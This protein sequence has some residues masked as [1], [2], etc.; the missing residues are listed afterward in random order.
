M[1]RSL[2]YWTAQPS[3]QRT[4]AE[5]IEDR[6]DVNQHIWFYASFLNWCGAHSQKL[7]DPRAKYPSEEHKVKTATVREVLRQEPLDVRE[8][9]GLMED[10][11]KEE[12]RAGTKTGLIR[13]P[14]QAS[15]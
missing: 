1:V 12:W 8:F 10:Y 9:I 6:F 2:K 3:D 15:E 13:A 5:W 14:H 4:I 7:K 11:F